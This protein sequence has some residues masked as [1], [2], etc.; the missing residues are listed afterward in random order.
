MTKMRWLVGCFSLLTFLLISAL[1]LG[2]NNNASIS[3]QV[4]DPSGAVIPGVEMKLTA[5]S[6][7]VVAHFTSGPDGLYGFQNLLRDTYVLSASAKGFRDFVQSGLTVN[8]NQNVRLDIKLELG[9][10]IQTVEVTANA[11][12]LNYENAS[13][14]QAIT[15]SEIGTLPLLMSGMKRNVVNY[16]VLMPGVTTGNTNGVEY[17]QVNGGM[18]EGDESTLDGVTM[19]EGLLNQSGTVSF[20]DMPIAPEVVD[21]VSLVASSYEPQY[22]MTTSSVYVVTTKSG[23][24]AFHG[25]AYEF[26]RNMDFN[27]RPYGTPTIPKDNENDY[28]VNIGGPAKIPYLWSGRSKTY[29]FFSFGGFKSVGTVTAPTYSFPTAEERTGNFSDYPYPVY[30]PATTAPINPGQPLSTSNVTRKQFMGCNGSTPNVICPTDPRLLA[31]L[32]QNWLTNV[33][34]PNKPGI[35]SNYVA[36]VGIPTSWENQNRYD[37]RV[38]EYLGSKDHISVT[39]H[40]GQ[41]PG[42]YESGLPF[43]ISTDSIRNRDHYHTP[44]INYDHTITP[45]LLNHFAIGYLDWYTHQYDFSDCC[46]SKMPQIPG[47]FSHTHQS[48]ITFDQYQGFGNNGDFTSTR[49][50]YAANDMVTWVRGKHTLKMGGEFRYYAYP[51]Y[52]VSNG[53]GT[54]SFTRLNTGLPGVP[55]GNDMASFEL[56]EVGDAS[57]EFYTVTSTH[58]QDEEMSAY[59]GDTWK[60]N[61][62]LSVNYGVRYDVNPPAKE[63]ENRFSFLDPT[64]PNPDA[65]GLLGAEVFAGTKW[66]PASFGKRY[67]ENVFY[68]G[69]APRIGIAYSLTPKTVIRTGYGIFFDQAFY[70]GW[71]G[72]I[73]ADGFNATPYI[74]SS[75]GGLSS[76]FLLQNGFPDTF[77]PPPNLTYGADNGVSVGAGDY[78][79]FD[80]NRLPYAQQWNLTVEHQFSENFYISAAY[81]GNKGTRLPSA[82]AP[83]N[84]INPSYLSLGSK[85]SDEFTAGQTSLDGVKIPYANWVSQMQGCVPTVAQALLPYPQYCGPLLGDNENAGNST[86]HSF[87]FKAERR[88]ARG[89]SLLVS[90]TNA[91]LIS[92]SDWTQT[93]AEDSTINAVSPFQRERNKGLGTADVPQTFSLAGEYLLPF[94]KGQRFLNN[95]GPLGKIL[96]GWTATT[97]FRLSSG[98]PFVFRNGAC[99]LPG[100]FAATCLPATGS[101][102]WAQKGSSFDPTKPL[103]NLASFQPTGALSTGYTL[104]SGSNVSN[105]RGFAFYNHDFGLIRD[106]TLTEHMRLEL[107]G[108]FFNIWNWHT[109]TNNFTTDV[110]SV[111][112]GMWNG[113][114]SNPR[115]IQFGAKFIF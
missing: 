106:V 40:Y 26:N 65:G 103:F 110:S 4:T 37:I 57:A 95:S 24:N 87:Q 90:Y 29:F 81:V 8:L 101:T 92:S 70:P 21:E 22:G 114:V 15:P 20:F 78:R 12:P 79:P 2:Q 53:S 59:V 32:A 97:V 42:L 85:L 18:I 45:N 39:E 23:T 10:A 107:R 28:G 67:P 9:A 75:L 91:K 17:A 109:F 89:S 83:L 1:C 94:G 38:D 35:L 19:Q 13:V 111:N 60:V 100:Q 88:F 84:A 64:Q 46:V 98:I 41:V 51:D 76:A 69:F 44:R 11:S 96:Q 66:G 27:S 43:I 71:A 16:A 68:K 49:P 102:P 74:P 54:F 82:V 115:N 108:E 52:S 58:P 104:G 7:G 31:S 80:A 72:G 6:T 25:S 99:D 3:G 62:K 113:T 55:S 30:D 5:G 77:T 34:L 63:K 61:H 36:P 33:P 86:Y 14:K 93:T 50:E 48:Q 105:M 56:G 112:F 73:Q 47:V